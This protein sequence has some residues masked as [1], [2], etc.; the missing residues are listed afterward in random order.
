M[1]AADPA[2]SKRKL[3]DLKG[4]GPAL[5]EKLARLN[6]YEPADLLFLL[7]Q[8]YEDR[9]RISRIGELIPGMRTVVEAEVELTEVV[10]R[11]RRTMLCKISDGSG[12]LTLR[13]F[14]FSKAQQNTLSK[15]KKLRC[16][17]EVRKGPS[18]YEMVHPEY[19][20]LSARDDAPLDDRL[21]PVYPTTE[22]LQQFRIRSLV[23]QALQHDLAGLT[24]LLPPET[25]ASE[26]LPELQEAVRYLHNP[27]QDAVLAELDEGRHP[28]QKRLALEEILAHHLSLRKIKDTAQ[29]EAGIAVQGNAELTQKFLAGLSFDLTGDQ[30]KALADIDADI[31]MPHPMMRLVQGDVG[32]GKT[33]VAAAAA[34]NVISAG[35]QVAVMAPTELLAEQHRDNFQKWLQPLGINVAWLTG[36]LTG[37]ARQQTYTGIAEGHAELIVGTHALFQEAVEY[38]SLGLVIVDEQHRFGVE[39]RLSLIEKGAGNGVL[40]HQLVMTATP[41]PRTLAMTMYAD[42][43]TSVIRELPPGRTPVTTVAIPDQRRGDVVTRIR[44]ACMSG[45]RAY[46]VCP[47]IE[48]SEV[49][50][51]Q[52]AETTFNVLKDQLPE[53]KIGL[54]HGRMK[55]AEKDRTMKQFADGKLNLLVATTVIEVGVDVPEATLMVI[56]NAERMGLSQ[57]HQLRGRVGRGAKQSA[58]VLLYKSPLSNV[59]EQRL[60]VMRETNDGFVVAQKDLELRGPGEVLGKRQTGAMQFRLA[61]LVRDADLMPLVHQLAA[62]LKDPEDSR[63]QSLVDALVDR[64]IGQD[65]EYVKV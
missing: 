51:Y 65:Q 27:P 56:E 3:T 23:E 61:D 41:I 17:G 6:V 38:H 50:D 5:A 52:A 26:G 32:C 55:P 53:L 48:D 1:T 15:G 37:K 60:N 29:L 28:C 39:Q 47:L 46:W 14:Y 49:L 35:H 63:V 4:V 18:G 12:I 16:F 34:L 22:G 19:T 54:I 11:R 9:T 20:L 21:T 8:R 62:E 43:D 2:A 25:L 10:F 31:A 58:C 7:P 64:W 57:L 40:P 13:F 33:V 24:N 42:L 44:E 59:A 45:Q 30:H 36:T